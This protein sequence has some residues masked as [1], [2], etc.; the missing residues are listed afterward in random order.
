MVAP[1][2]DR[3]MKL[4]AQLPGLGPRSGKRAA[5]HLIKRQTTHLDPL[6]EALTQVRASVKTCTRCGNL[7]TQDICSICTSEKRT[8]NLVCVVAQVEDLWA[9]ERSGSYQGLYHVLGGVL[10]ALDGVTPEDLRLA[11]LLERLQ[12]GSITEVII[13]LNATVEG[14]TTAYYVHEKLSAAFPT[15]TITRLAHGIPIGGDLDYLDEGTI[16]AALE[17]RRPLA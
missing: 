15:I 5:L 6:V 16:L 13:A 9:M 7:D 2:I 14:Q 3:L 4:L 1:E 10:S 12:D 8:K 11:P 17:A